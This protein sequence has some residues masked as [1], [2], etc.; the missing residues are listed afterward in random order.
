MNIT[1]RKKCDF[2]RCKSKWFYKNKAIF[3]QIEAHLK[4]HNDIDL[5]FE[6]K[7]LK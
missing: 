1:D 7:W 5:L 4:T 6:I 2:T 3:L